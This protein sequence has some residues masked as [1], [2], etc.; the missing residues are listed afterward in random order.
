MKNRIPFYSFLLILFIS[1]CS[2]YS[3]VTHEY[4]SSGDFFYT[5]GTNICTPEGEP[6]IIKGIAFG[7]RVWDNPSVPP[8]E[9]HT[10]ES[11][12]KM[13]A[14]GFNTVRFYIN[15]GL[16][17]SDEGPYKYQ[18]T[19]FEWLRQNIRWAKENGIYLIVN[20]HYPQGGYQSNGEGLELFEKKSNQKRLAALWNAI[21]REFAEEPAILGWGIVNEPVPLY[22]GK[23]AESSLKTWE[24]LANNLVEA[25]RKADKNH[26]IFV[27]KANGI[28]DSDGNWYG[29][30]LEHYYPEI[31]DG[32]FAYEAHFYEPLWYTHQG[33]SWTE[34][35]F[36]DS[37]YPDENTGKMTGDVAWYGYQKNITPISGSTETWIDF[38]PPQVKI[39][40]PE[41]SSVAAVVQAGNLMDTGTVYIDDVVLEEYDQEDKFVRVVFQRDF[42]DETDFW[43]WCENPETGKA[44]IC[45]DPE[46][47]TGNCAVISG[48][49]G[50]ANI[51]M[52]FIPA[53]ENYSYKLKLKLKTQG[54]QEGAYIR[55]R[56]D[57]GTGGSPLCFNRDY[58]KEKILSH[59]M[60][61]DKKNKPLYI[62]EF[63]AY[64][65][66]FEENPAG[67]NRGGA[68]YIKDVLNI[69]TEEKIGFTF[70]AYHEEAF[71][72]YQS[73]P[74]VYPDDKDLNQE[75]YQIFIN[76]LDK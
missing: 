1:S 39:T 30:D 37:I 12:R 44:M 71:G 55:G 15:Y 8:K 61:T 73:S 69:F 52:E 41:I 36:S 43:L 31:N 10:A 67:I 21:A 42:E 25:I 11:Y 20:M 59:K 65:P 35:Q 14:L 68:E 64:Y 76:E 3:N 7:N 51:T 74:W 70:H 46:G 45:S 57:F 16:F 22:D 48:T 5:Y 66:V 40:D 18:E 29:T 13:K 2:H 19:G 63:G 23:S 34:N 27:E 6:F 47:K 28:K 53:K 26:I 72:L 4:H 17:E 60:I 38:A 50:D 32:N 62:G 58:L 49:R 75:L 33:T 9:H 24:E 56:L 54:I